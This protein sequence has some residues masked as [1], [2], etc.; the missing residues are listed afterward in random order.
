MLALECRLDS[1]ICSFLTK[2]L[3]PTRE[4]H[5]DD[6]L[7][8]F[9]VPSFIA[10]RACTEMNGYFGSRITN[11]AE[12]KLQSTSAYG[13]I[14]ETLDSSNMHPHIGLWFRC[15]I[16]MVR[17]VPEYSHEH[18]PEF[19]GHGQEYRWYEMSFMSRWDDSGRCRIL[20]FDVPR[21]LDLKLQAALRKQPELNFK[22]PFAMHRHLI[23]QII[24]L[25]DISV[26][27]LRDHVRLCEKVNIKQRAHT[28][29]FL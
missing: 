16:K 19:V 17:K 4:A 23:D 27:R 14:R 11:N 13:S 29:Y 24:D 25:Y 28:S 7:A 2:D 21:G 9:E 15:L 12:D 10:S 6:L 26:W 1:L 5:R 3:Y 18:G 22:D 8:Q 20:S